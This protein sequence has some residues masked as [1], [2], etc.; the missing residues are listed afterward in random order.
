MTVGQ[1]NP[2]LVTLDSGQVLVRG[3]YSQVPGRCGAVTSNALMSAELYNPASGM[4]SLTGS[5]SSPRAAAAS[6][7]L[8]TGEA[9]IVDGEQYGNSPFNS[10]AEIYTPGADGGAG[11]AFTWSGTVPGNAGYS[12][13]FTLPSGQVLV[14]GSS[15]N[16]GTI[17]LFDPATQMFAPATPNLISGGGGCNIRL[18]SGDVFFATGYP[19]QAQ[20]AQTEVYQASTGTWTELGKMSASRWVCSIA[21]LPNGNV[22]VAG[23]DDPSG[24]PLATAEVCNPRPPAG[25]QAGDA[26]VADA[27]ADAPSD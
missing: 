17:S 8:P 5:A 11:G 23:G 16:A 27:A 13:A 25:A 24:T 3:G 20:S 2:V 12:F 22:L 6:T 10:T 7:L 26:G 9:L 19:A 18:K 21:E 4:F 15:Y 1:S 14:S